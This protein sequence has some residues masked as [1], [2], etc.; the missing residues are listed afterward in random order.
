MYNRLED[1][2]ADWATV[3]KS[4]PFLKWL[5][6]SDEFSGLVRGNLLRAA[7]DRNDADR[8]IK[9]FKSFQKEHVV[10]TTDPSADAPTDETPSEETPAEEPQQTLDEL[11]APGTPKTGSTGAQ[12]ESGKGRIW[13]QK[14]IDEFYGWKN[15]FV[16]KNPGKDL[17]E[18][19]AREERDLFKAQHEGRI[20]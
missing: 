9:I 18:E 7:F 11:V 15:E 1:A 16:K 6:E 19:M 3:N 12:E 2:V 14:L 5:D 17:P 13:N 10:D 8:V 4:E 20:R